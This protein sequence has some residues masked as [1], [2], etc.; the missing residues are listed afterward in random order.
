VIARLVDMEVVVCPNCGEENPAK[1]RLCGYCG[2]ALAPA[3]PPQEVRKTVTIVFS[4][5]K[6]S[7]NLGEALDPESLREVMTRY[8]DSMKAVLDLHGGT[9]EKYIGDAIMAV[10]GLPRLH[11][12][13]A[14]RAVRAAHGMQAALRDLNRDLL[15]TYGVELT[16]RTG[17]NTGEVVA[18][19]PTT[20][21]RLV[22]GDAVNTAARLE[23][24]APANEILIGGLTY[25]L[26]RGQVE[27]EEVEPLELKGKAERVPAYRLVGIG[28][29]ADAG[30]QESPL[31]GRDRELAIL[32]QAL[33]DAYV[34]QRCRLVT[35]VGEAGVGKS[36]LI[37]E[38]LE[39]HEPDAVTLRG[40]CLSY[41]EA[42][43]FWPVAEA[44]RMAA[45]IADDDPPETAQERILDLLDADDPEREQVAA[46]VAAAIGLTPAQVPVS[47]LFYGIRRLFEALAADRPLIVLF[48]DIH[49]AAPTFL[50][51]IDHLIESSQRV[52]IVLVCSARHELLEEHPD[53]EGRPGTATIKLEPLTAADAELFIDRLLGE[54]RLPDDV[55]RRVVEAAEGN[56]LYVEQMVGMLAD[57]RMP[58]G[59]DITDFAVPPSIQALIAAR[60]DL[61]SREER[62]VVEPASVIG[63]VFPE[64]AV[65]ELVP[66]PLKSSLGQHLTTLNRKQFVRPAQDGIAADDVD[67]YRFHHILIRD[68][69]YNALLKRARATLHERFVA[70]AE[71]VNRER[72]REQEFEEIL[73]YHLEQ[74]YRYRTELGPLDTEGRAIGVRAAQRLGAAGRRA[75]VRGDLP[76]ATNLLARA[77]ALRGA[78]DPERIE[79]LGD[80]GEAQVERGTFS[81]ASSTLQEAAEAARRI[82]DERLEARARLTSFAVDL[83]AG[84]VENLE[85]AVPSAERAIATFESAGDE[86]GIARAWRLLF[87][88]H[89]TNGGYDRAA[90]AAEQIIEHARI[91]GDAR[92]A[93][94]G[95]AGYA[96][97]ALSGSLPTSE[98]IPRCEQ[99]MAQT[100]G[101][102]K[103]QAV[104]AGSLAQLYA[105][106]GDFAK[107]RE[108]SER[109]RQMLAELGPSVTASSTSLERAR[110][111]ILAGDLD[112]AE[113]ALRADD[114]ALAELGERYFRST[115]V[116]MLAGVLA[117]RGLTDEG[118][119]AVETARELADADDV[120]SQALSR[121]ARSRLL[122]DAGRSDE[123]VAEAEAAVEIVESSADIDLLGDAKV[124][125]GE[126]LARAGRPEAAGPPFREALALFERKE[127]RVSAERVAALLAGL[128]TAGSEP[129]HQ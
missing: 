115:I 112:A 69:A 63:L 25:A 40:R 99:L 55:R 14:L 2:T 34:T 64:Q 119:Q 113:R 68:T 104:I 73:G 86:A 103:S 15:A 85:E 33:A 78:D 13:D 74:A 56:P 1:F 37:S 93:A 19:D 107:G 109:Q 49:D 88:V 80:L 11:E 27:V 38:F 10:F 126:V 98:L 77:A 66:D 100:A 3:L 120:A 62:A 35:V 17:V 30:R 101:D 6:G 39:E 111:E 7:T 46:R 9:I 105:M 36:R 96:S 16:N 20:G 29:G 82:G 71:E 76:A 114:E 28:E 44:V 83:Y 118:E 50:E 65:Q 8:F 18:G 59:S 54:T 21:Q 84:R 24:A 43:T 32:E 125:L 90:A 52:P 70:W 121:I 102:R 89:G 42:I 41:G 124:E 67:A 72:D 108:L 122:A 87:F 48:D 95:A 60:L 22:T 110:V 79:L 26:V 91:A 58:T 47:E 57:E 94:R 81:E 75:F 127:N 31:V 12:D 128:P 53:W 123:A 92:M 61:L 4:D 51:L 129:A 23:Q 97:V 45:D 116:A 106:Q 117:R 5:L